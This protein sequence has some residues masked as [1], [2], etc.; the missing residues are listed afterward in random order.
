MLILPYR[1]DLKHTGTKEGM[2]TQ[3]TTKTADS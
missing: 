2:E 3:Q 1:N